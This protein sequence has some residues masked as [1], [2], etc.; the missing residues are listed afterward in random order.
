MAQS[1][2]RINHEGKI[3]NAKIGRILI[4]RLS[5]GLQ[6]GFSSSK[7]LCG[8][9]AQFL[10]QTL[11]WLLILQPAQQKDKPNGP[12]TVAR[13]H[14]MEDSKLEAKQHILAEC[15]RIQRA[16]VDN[17]RKAMN[18]AQESA[19]E[20]DDSTEEKL[21]NSY[22]EEMHNKRDMFARHFELAMDDLNQLNQIVTSKEYHRAEFGS[23]VETDGGTYF[24]S[25]SLGQ[26]KVDGKVIFAVSA[27]A[28]VYKAFEG[29]KAGDAFSF[30]D[31]SFKI[32]EIY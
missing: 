3:R 27:L 26:V 28:P 12:I 21:Y 31:K 1:H 8:R 15:L 18:D 16:V 14:Y 6:V 22:R 11:V 30:R 2:N 9:D 20:G 32:K 4:V 13:N 24:I 19:N 10:L 5:F 23:V 7:I 25:T 17:A 29:K